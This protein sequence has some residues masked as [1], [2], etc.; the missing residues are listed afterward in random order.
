[1]KGRARW[2]VWA[3]QPTISNSV[4]WP[5]TQGKTEPSSKSTSC[6]ELP[7]GT[8]PKP[9]PGWKCS[10]SQPQCSQCACG[11]RRG[12]TRWDGNGKGENYSPALPRASTSPAAWQ[13]KV[14]FIIDSKEGFS[15]TRC[16][17]NMC[18]WSADVPSPAEPLWLEMI[19]AGNPMHFHLWNGLA[20][21]EC[22]GFNLKILRQDHSNTPP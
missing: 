2:W 17:K 18:F 13:T 19:Y 14:F 7:V 12:E 6:S 15:G 16:C 4:S 9:I 5:G 20:C 1:M 10:Q 22:E 8:K 21:T 3:S 11:W